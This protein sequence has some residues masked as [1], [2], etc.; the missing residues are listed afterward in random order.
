M[1]LHK[2]MATTILGLMLTLPLMAGDVI[3]EG[4]VKAAEKNMEAITAEELQKMV[5]DGVAFVALDVREADMRMEGT[6]DAENNVEIARGVLEFDVGE[7]IP[8]RKALVVV[9]CR[10]GKSA[11]LAAQTMKYHLGYTN[12]RYL[13]GGLD[14]WMEEG[15]SIYNHFGEVTL[16][17]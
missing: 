6:F 4:L 16:A 3:S 9:Y 5:D 13:K 1:K 7:K 11:V 17:K 10:V 15:H 14:A 2:L 12:V 8:D